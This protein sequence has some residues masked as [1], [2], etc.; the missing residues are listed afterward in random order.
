MFWNQCRFWSD[1]FITIWQLGNFAGIFFCL[2][3]FQ[4]KFFF[5]K[6]E[7]FQ[8]YLQR[9]KQFGSRS[10]PTFVRPDL[11]QNCLQRLS[12]DNTSGQRVKGDSNPNDKYVLSERAIQ[13]MNCDT[14]IIKIGWKMGK[15]CILKEF[16]MANIKPPFWIFNYF[17]E[18]FQ[19]LNF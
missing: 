19:M 3:I 9:V 2:L 15:L 14:S 10:G 1:G 6:N 18:Y 17:S 5:T 8:E 16:N 13:T 11:G 12:A 7:F 4:T